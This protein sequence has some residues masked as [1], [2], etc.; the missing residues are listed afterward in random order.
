MRHF[1]LL[2]VMRFLI[3]LVFLPAF[4]FGQIYKDPETILE[5]L[6]EGAMLPEK[7]L[8][9]RSVVLY[10]PNLTVKEVNTI[11]DRLVQTGID[12]VA[13]FETDRI[14]AGEDVALAFSQYF[15]KREIDNFVIFEKKVTGFRITVTL[16]SGDQRILNPA[17]AVWRAQH[18]SLQEALRM[19]YS[20][21]LNAYRR[22]NMLINE[23]PE[24]ELTIPVIEGRRTEAFAADLKVD[25]LAVQKFGNEVLDKELEDI[26][27][28]YPFKYALV[29]NTIPEPEL[30]K[31]GYFYILRFVC[32]RGPVAKQLL[33]YEVNPLEAVVSISYDNGNER[34]KTI[35]TDTPVYK[36]YTRQIQFNNV[37]LGTRWD[38][39]IT[40][41][42]ALKNFVSG[43][44]KTMRVN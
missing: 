30:R 13:Y 16:F 24:T 33:G 6:A 5:T 28:D 22:Q 39:D 35:P 40:W 38:A 44:R 32:S 4:T 17:Q 8:S 29:E 18:E 21:A 2:M 15:L 31:Q 19:L 20:T 41:Q 43:F 34:I 37:Y 27:R 10:T 14:F 25:R 12:A 3:T 9:A 36:F 26:M 11:H 23:V 42:Q 1:S 7:I